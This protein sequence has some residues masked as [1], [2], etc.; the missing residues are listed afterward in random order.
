MD[1]AGAILVLGALYAGT[2]FVFGLAFVA[3]G[4]QRVDHSAAGAPWS[5]RLVILPGAAALWPLMLIKWIRAS[6]G[7]RQGGAL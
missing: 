4:V 5:F 3:V 6:R 2:G 7:L 1:W